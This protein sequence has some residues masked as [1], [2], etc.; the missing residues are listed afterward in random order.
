MNAYYREYANLLAEI[1]GAGKV[2]KI[3]IDVKASC[4][5]RDGTKGYGG[6]TY[7]NNKAFSP[8]YD[9]RL[10]SVSN[11]IE[12]GKRFFARK[13]KDMRYVAY[14][15]SYTSTHGRDV[16]DVIKLYEEAASQPDVAGVI[17]ATRP[18]C[19]PDILLQR[20]AEMAR[21][22][23]VAIEYGAESSHD[24]ILA[25]VNRCHTWAQTVDAVMRTHA[26]GIPVGLHLIMGLP[27]ETRQMM[28]QTVRR[29]NELP[30]SSVK[31]HQLQVLKG[32]AMASAPPPTFTLDEYL[33]LC[34]DIVNILRSDIAIERF[35]SQ[36]PP[37]MLLA[38]KWGLKNYQFTHLLFKALQSSRCE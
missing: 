34:V 19:M 7:C 23:P 28:M 9:K 2:Q 22:T 36:A 13:Y 20:I 16:D 14:F 5:N 8:D 24:D 27:G 37:D 17:I 12:Q 18:D 31:F 15:Q 1:F 38:P 32:T 21:H 10:L 35:I 25:A 33:A 3:A 11:Q 29:V 30:V 26:A 4:P 6:C